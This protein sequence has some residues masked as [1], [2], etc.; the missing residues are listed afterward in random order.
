M[1]I[2]GTIGEESV[3]AL[4]AGHMISSSREICALGPALERELREAE[5][6][7]ERRRAEASLRENE[8]LLSEAQRLGHIGSWSLDIRRDALQ[9]SDEMYHL[10]DIFPNEFQHNS[11]GFLDLIYSA[12]R[13]FAS[14]WIERSSP[15]GR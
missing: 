15:G 8:R 14:K 5:V 6:R 10:L 11:L 2:S 7:H 1:I 12:D 4:I 9:F 13:L 3:S